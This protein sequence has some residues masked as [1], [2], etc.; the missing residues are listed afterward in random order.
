[1]TKQQQ[2]YAR[3]YYYGNKCKATF[4]SRQAFFDDI[5]NPTK[6]K[7]RLTLRCLSKGHTPGNLMWALHPNRSSRYQVTTMQGNVACLKAACEQDGVKYPNVSATLRRYG[8]E[9]N[10]SAAFAFNKLAKSARSA[11]RRQVVAKA[12]SQLSA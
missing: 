1:M 5:G 9:D 8:L 3:Q 7:M 6:A 4:G 12:I 2:G 11:F 10:P